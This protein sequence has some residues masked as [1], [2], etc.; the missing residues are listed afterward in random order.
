MQTETRSHPNPIFLQELKAWR[1]LQEKLP[2]TR[3]EVLEA[4]REN[5][6][7]TLMELATI[8]RRPVNRVSGRIT[9]FLFNFHS[10]SAF[11]LIKVVV[12]F[13]PSMGPDLLLEQPHPV[14][15]DFPSWEI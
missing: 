13:F 7:S 8:L 2:A 3:K 1:E 5:Q 15:L 10:L 12:S 4:V 9:E 11:S 14:A 6:Y